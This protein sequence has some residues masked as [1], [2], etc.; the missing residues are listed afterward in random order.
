[1]TFNICLVSRLRAKVK[2]FAVTFL[3]LFHFLESAFKARSFATAFLAFFYLFLLL[4]G[5]WEMD[6]LNFFCQCFIIHYA[7]SLWPGSSYFIRHSGKCFRP[8]SIPYDILCS[9]MAWNVLERYVVMTELSKHVGFCSSAAK[10]IISPLPWCL[11]PPNLVRSWRTMRNSRSIK[12][13]DP[14]ITWSCMI[15]WKIK[16]LYLQYYSTYGHKTCESG[17]I[18]LGALTHTVKWSFIT[19][20]CEVPWQIKYVIFPVAK[21]LWALTS[22]R[23]WLTVRDSNA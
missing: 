2:R 5:V 13:H 23:W 6:M 17:D 1:M 16:T 19:W 11:W 9:W 18:P 7:E 15:T 3:F 8:C 12:P 4:L 21:D 20:S 10:T 14:L 22:A